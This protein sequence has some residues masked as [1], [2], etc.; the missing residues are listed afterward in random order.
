MVTM[1][2]RVSLDAHAAPSVTVIGT[3]LPILEFP[4]WLAADWIK[5][6]EAESTT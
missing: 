2:M 3:V 1:A 5:V 6:G 4:P